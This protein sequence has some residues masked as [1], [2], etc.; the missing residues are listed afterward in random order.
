[1]SGG[2][3]I[4]TSAV[5]AYL[6]ESA[7][8]CGACHSSSVSCGRSVLSGRPAVHSLPAALPQTTSKQPDH[9]PGKGNTMDSTESLSNSRD[10]LI[11]RNCHKVLRKVSRTSDNY[12]C[13]CPGGRR[14]TSASMPGH[15]TLTG[16]LR[17]VEMGAELSLEMAQTSII[18]HRDPLPERSTSVVIGAD[19]LC[20]G[21]CI[22]EYMGSAGVVHERRGGAWS[23]QGVGASSVQ[24]LARAGVV[25]EACRDGVEVCRRWR[26]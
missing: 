5:W 10:Y 11:C 9:R 1:M 13:N 8:P 15:V 3:V 22:E 2:E 7:P 16:S 12:Y 26:K 18:P 23:V 4:Y 6:C 20:R 19:V 21:Q 24:E 14:A 17:L 25:L